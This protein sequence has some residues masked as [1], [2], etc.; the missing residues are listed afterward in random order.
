LKHYGTRT[1]ILKAKLGK[2]E[3]VSWDTRVIRLFMILLNKRMEICS[4]KV[5]LMTIWRENYVMIKRT[6]C[7]DLIPFSAHSRH[8]HMPMILY[9][10]IGSSGEVSCDYS[11]SITMNPMRSYKTFFFFLCERTSIYPWVQLIE[12]SQPT[13]FP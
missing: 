12:P 6:F 8:H 7:I 9:R 2:F 10:I 1:W 4:L 13:T 3:R 5:W 11:P